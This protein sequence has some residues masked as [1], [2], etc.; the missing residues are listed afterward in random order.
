MPLPI[1]LPSTAPC[2][3]WMKNSKQEGQFWAQEKI[4]TTLNAWA[5]INN[6]R[7]FLPDAKRAGSRAVAGRSVWRVIETHPVDGG[8]ESMHSRA[9]IGFGSSFWVKSL[10][11]KHQFLIQ[12]SVR[13]SARLF[14]PQAQ[15]AK[16]IVREVKP[17][18][19]KFRVAPR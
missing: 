12:Y 19:L 13:P 15:C 5:L 3:S 8:A 9:I 17:S 16:N 7:T 18:R 6:L 11:K 4:N 1:L 14:P 2:V 10:S